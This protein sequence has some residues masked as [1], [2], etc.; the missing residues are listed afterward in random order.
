MGRGVRTHRALARR[1]HST[2]ALCVHV[3]TAA[4]IVPSATRLRTGAGRAR[5]PPP[6]INAPVTG[7][8]RETTM[9][10]TFGVRPSRFLLAAGALTLTLAFGAFIGATAVGA[11]GSAAAPS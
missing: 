6:A 2:A 4:R 5:T 9:R 11:R 8:V 10:P 1:L 3:R 7:R